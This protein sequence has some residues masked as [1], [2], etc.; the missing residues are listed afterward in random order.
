MLSGPNDLPD[1]KGRYVVSL[2]SASRASDDTSVPVRLG[3]LTRSTLSRDRMAG[4]AARF[5][6]VGV[7]NTVVDLV[8]FFLLSAIPGMPDTAAKAIS[9]FLGICN[10]FIWNKYWTFRARR[11]KHGPRE[12]AFFLGVNTFPMVVNVVVFTALGL[13]IDSGSFVVRMA[14][15]FAAAV[16]ST[17]WNFFGSR[18]F[19]FRQTAVKPGTKSGVAPTSVEKAGTAAG[20]SAAIP[21]RTEGKGRG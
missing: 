19:A 14:K 16:V 18:Y 21:G 20:E 13:W 2:R 15:A 10:S 6:V 3:R 8:A 17:A 12:F 7:L 1:V 5:V 11:S 4:Q 9:Y